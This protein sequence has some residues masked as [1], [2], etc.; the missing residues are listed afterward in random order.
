MPKILIE[1]ADLN[2][3][4]K[5]VESAERAAGSCIITYAKQH[6]GLVEAGVSSGAS[7]SARIISNDSDETPQ[8]ARRKIQRGLCE[9]AHDGQPKSKQ[10]ETIENMEEK[11]TVTEDH[12]GDYLTAIAGRAG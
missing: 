9:I 11:E 12:C 1:C 2:D 4:T 5:V 6:L 10:I 3:F 7:E 8:A